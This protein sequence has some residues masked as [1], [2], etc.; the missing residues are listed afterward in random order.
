MNTC[1]VVVEE[2]EVKARVLVKATYKCV[3]ILPAVKVSRESGCQLLLF[4]I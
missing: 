1:V 4:F 2:S 3:N